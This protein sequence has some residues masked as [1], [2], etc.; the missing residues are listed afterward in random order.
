MVWARFV[1]LVMDDRVL[2]KA[3]VDETEVLRAVGLEGKGNIELSNGSKT[4]SNPPKVHTVTESPSHPHNDHTLR[5]ERSRQW[6]V[7]TDRRLS[8]LAH[9]VVAVLVTSDG[10]R[11]RRGVVLWAHCLLGNCYRSL[12]T[13][14]PILLEAL[15]ALSHDDYQQVS[16]S[17]LLSLVSPPHEVH[18]SL[19]TSLPPPPLSL[20][21]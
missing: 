12:V 10:W 19:F 17:A 13:V 18:C 7:E 1:G 2:C 14:A 15:L 11:G 21:L 9:K 5:V 20:S 6:R 16:S 4:P 3:D 8:V